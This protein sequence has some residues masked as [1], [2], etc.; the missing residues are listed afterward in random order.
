MLK[1]IWRNYNRYIDISARESKLAVILGI[2]GAL[3]ETFS[4]YLLANLI[5]N[6]DKNKLIINIKFFSPIFISKEIF[7][8]FFLISAML[9]ASFYYLSNKNIVKS[10]CLTEKFVREEITDLTLNIKWEYYLQISQGDISKSILSEGQNI[11]EGYM[12]FI[13]AIT[14]SFIAITY[15]IAC[16]IL[17]PDTFFILIIYAIFAYRI[18]LFYSRKANKFGKELSNITSNIGQWTAA[19][20]N[21]LKYLKAISKDK[22]AKEES[23]DIFIKFANSYENARVASFK[24]KFIT[25]IMTIIFIFLAITFI[26]IRGSNTSNLILS[27]SLFVR[28]TPKIYNAQIRLLDSLAMV[29]WPKGH[30]ERIKWAKVHKDI[31]YKNKKKFYFDGKIIFDSV[32]FNYPN[33]KYI[34]NNIN[35]IIEKNDCIGITGKSGIGKST[36]LDLITGLIKPKKGCIY[37]SGKDMQNINIYSWREKL[38]IVMQ[39]NFFKNE[40]LASNIALGKKIDKNKIKDSLIKANAWDFVRL[41]PNGIDEMILDRGLRFS[42]G[43][44]QRIALARALYNDPQVLILDEPSTGLDKTSENKLI[45]SIKKLKGTINI[46]I[47]SHK[48]ELVTIC[49]KAFSLDK[50]GLKKI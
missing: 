15:F 40:T 31:I 44:R 7:I 30:Y 33:C 19:I 20:F 43:E 8:L 48:K 22:L 2:T 1:N 27:L 24:S 49:D 42:G 26:L 39:E 35:L 29:S 14:Y 32:Y 13:S 28:M 36:L 46:I 12:Y 6:L 41:L 5:T 3:T 25:E 16:L 4:I 38:G 21:N 47:I 50:E 11:S 17:V 45:S 23:R 9:A 37:L 18:Y 10:K 34:L